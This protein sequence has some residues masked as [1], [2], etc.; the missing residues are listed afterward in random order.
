M[1]FV[2]GKLKTSH[3]NR[4][5][6]I[7]ND[8]VVSSLIATGLIAIGGIVWSAI[9]STFDKDVDFKTAFCDFL[10]LKIELWYFLILILLIILIIWLFRHFRKEIF[11]YDKDSLRLDKELFVRIRNV[12]LPQP[13]P[14]DFIRENNFAGF[15]FVLSELDGLYRISNESRNSDFE[16]FNPELEQHK[17]ELV[18]LIDDFNVI[19]SS[20][21]FVTERGFQTVPPEWE[22]TQPERFRKVV[23]DINR[24]QDGICE[25]YDE[26]LKLGRRILKV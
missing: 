20:E 21:T 12:L 6:K 25:K 8:P 17:K 1:L 16:F 2:N 7:W 19:I 4:Y 26:F 23:K 5:K 24:L 22:Q 11:I 15:S 13:G 9:K 14:I 10:T 18:K 3:M